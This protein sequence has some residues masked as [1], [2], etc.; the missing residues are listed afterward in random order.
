MVDVAKHILV[1][2][3]MI[4]RSTT[5]HCQGYSIW[6]GPSEIPIL[7]Q[8]SLFH[9]LHSTLVIMNSI[10]YFWCLLLAIVGTMVNPTN[11]YIYIYAKDHLLFMPSSPSTV[12]D[13]HQYPYFCLILG[14]DPFMTGCC[15]SGTETGRKSQDRCQIQAD[16]P[17][18]WDT[19]GWWMK[20]IENT[21]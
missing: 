5:I 18:W 3:L 19:W 16:P 12:C 20:A 11:V 4:I 2:Y 6:F 15:Q 13:N 14:W 1:L 8:F 10:Q 9:F 7:I 21:M 17:P